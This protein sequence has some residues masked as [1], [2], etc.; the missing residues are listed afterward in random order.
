MQ[1]SLLLHEQRLCVRLQSATLPAPVSICCF[2][3]QQRKC[4][5]ELFS[6]HT[7]GKAPG[8]DKQKKKSLHKFTQL[9]L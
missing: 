6:L 4:Y 9:V 5:T 1:D 8:L 3:D 2:P 7:P